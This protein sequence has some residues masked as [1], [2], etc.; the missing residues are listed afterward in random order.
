MVSGRNEANVVWDTLR[1]IHTNE[2]KSEII[3]H[4]AFSLLHSKEILNKSSHTH[5]KIS[6]ILKTNIAAHEEVPHNKTIDD[7]RLD[8][9]LLSFGLKKWEVPSDGD[10]LFTSVVFFL[11][12]VFKLNNENE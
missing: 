6:R 12:K 4:N 9:V 8:N 3:H 5:T 1:M 7:S 10:C 2:K 11:G